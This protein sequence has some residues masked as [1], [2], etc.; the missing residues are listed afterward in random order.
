MTAA[1]DGP[2]I[3]WAQ[4]ERLVYYHLTRWGYFSSHP[5]YD[6]LVQEGR[7]ALWKAAQTYRPEVGAP[8]GSYAS[9]CIRHAIQMWYRRQ[10]R[11]ADQ[12]EVSLETPIAETADG[13]VVTVGETLVQSGEGPEEWALYRDRLATLEQWMQQLTPSDQALL[14]QRWAGVPQK[15][16]AQRMGRHRTLVYKRLK[17][18]LGALAVERSPYGATARAPLYQ[19]VVR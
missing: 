10:L 12:R 19:G 1:A 5:D 3:D 17:Q 2:T 7:I 16:L 6:D 15:E 8:W 11:Q 4:H 14:R 18:L 9:V 13:E